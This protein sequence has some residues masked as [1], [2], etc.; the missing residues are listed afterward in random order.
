MN[1]T[2]NQTPYIEVAKEI[3]KAY[4]KG[5]VD[6]AGD[7]YYTGHLTK[8]ASYV[9]TDKEKAVA[10]LHDIIEDTDMTL[11]RLVH[12]LLL[13][14]DTNEDAFNIVDAVHAMSKRGYENYDA[15]LKRVKQ[16]DL[17]RIVKLADLKHNS[18]LSR[19]KTITD[20]DI[21]RTEKY[22]KAIK[23]LS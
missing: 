13:F 15:Y 18:D 16:N 8:V 23:Y 17:V 11:Y 5:Q 21:K 12:Q 10:Y 6:K 1:D 3:A 2:I 7:D 19:L 14:T 4:H 9:N 20:K 22:K